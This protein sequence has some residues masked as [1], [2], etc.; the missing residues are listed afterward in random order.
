MKKFFWI[1][2]SML[3]VFTACKKNSD[4]TNNSGW[5]EEEKASYNNVLTLQDKAF[6]NYTSWLQTMDSL[7]AINKLKQF[8]LSDPLVSSAAIGAQGITVQYAAV[9]SALILRT[10]PEKTP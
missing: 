3:I 2:L 1:F 10:T 8:F 5:T 7:E 4:D 9:E 6:E